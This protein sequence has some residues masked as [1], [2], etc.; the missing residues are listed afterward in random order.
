MTLVFVPYHEKKRYALNHVFD[1]VERAELPDCE[2]ILRWHKG[3]YGEKDAVKKQR[4]F[5]RQL[6]ADKN[7]DYLLFIGADTIPPLDVLPRL[8]AHNKPVVGG[9]YYGRK[10]ATNGNPKA[11]VAWKHDDDAQNWLSQEGLVELDGMGMDC[12]LFS[13]EAF[14]SFSFD[15]WKVNDDDYPAYDLLRA[16]GFPCLMDATIVCRH[17]NTETEYS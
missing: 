2:I 6:A 15:D 12:V 8:L 1:W 9:I 13:R 3:T 4:E 11:A 10:H 16:K 7:A 14:T 17:Y 5:A